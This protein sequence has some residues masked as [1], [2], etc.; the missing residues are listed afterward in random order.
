MHLLRKQTGMSLMVHSLAVI[1]L[2]DL[3]LTL[4]SRDWD[5]PRLFTLTALKRRGFP[6][7][8][9]NMFCGKVGR[10]LIMTTVSH[11]FC[12]A[13]VCFSHT[14]FITLAPGEE[15]E[16]NAFGSVCLSVCLSV[17][18]RKSRTISPIFLHKK[19][20]PMARSFSKMV[21]IHDPDLG[22]RL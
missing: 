3:G 6:A 22:P 7:E 9:I 5:D 19:Y 15:C 18:T 13:S 14:V 1:T 2:C 11:G 10:S 17:R 12:L 21:R 16:G 8:A 20:V 4:T